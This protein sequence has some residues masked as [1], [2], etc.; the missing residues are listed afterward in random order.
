MLPGSC[1]ISSV[2][3]ELLAV[4][5]KLDQHS[6]VAY[7]KKGMGPVCSGNGEQLSNYSEQKWY[8]ILPD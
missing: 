2:S 6:A 8:A 7:I 4:S 3:S 1:P 5:T